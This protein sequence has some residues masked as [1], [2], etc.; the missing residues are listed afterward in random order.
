MKIDQCAEPTFA[1]HESFQP[2][3]GWLK[4]AVDATSEDPAV[5]AREDAVVRLGVGKNMV[6]A[7][8]FWGL[9]A[10]VL[11]T[12]P[13][14]EHP[15]RPLVVPS[16]L[17]AGLLGDGGL[18]P[19]CEDPATL[20]LLHWMFLSP[21][22]LLPVWWAALNEFPAVEF[23]AVELSQFITEYFG[24]VN[25][26]KDPVESSLKKDLDCFLRMYSSGDEGPRT[27]ADDL[28]DCPFG[29]LGLLRRGV[30][31]RSY[32]FT[33]GEKPSLPPAVVLYACLDFVARTDSAAQTVTLSRLIT[34]KGGPARALKLTDSAL[35][36]LLVTACDEL[37]G[38]ALTSA[39]G[40]AQLALSDAPAALASDALWRHYNNSRP[41]RSK[42]ISPLAGLAADLPSQGAMG[43]FE[44]QAPAAAPK[45]SRR[46]DPH[47]PEPADRLRA[48]E[49][50]QARLD[51]GLPTGAAK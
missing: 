18:D 31:H 41:P 48:L 27:T 9:A 3:H 22:S 23:S 28:V 6:R 12:A 30:E 45:R 29:E 19:Y 11:A 20:W 10:K 21:R 33:M 17:G 39:A 2:R 1:R 24:G 35:E 16:N 32:R 38:V 34:E 43:L 42:L 44:M 13:N 26:W 36:D 47:G 4:K 51:V 8:R 37:D 50:N 49:W 25:Q 40:V 46:V 7:I 15:R 14:P 5:F